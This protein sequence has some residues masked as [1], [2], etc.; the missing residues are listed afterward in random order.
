MEI[1]GSVKHAELLFRV[2]GELSQKA[3]GA[4]TPAVTIN[5]L[6]IE[7]PKPIHEWPA[8]Y[9]APQSVSHVDPGSRAGAGGWLPTFRPPD[10]HKSSQV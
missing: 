6:G 7:G 1:R 5:I 10:A 8:G 9:R 4:Q 2:T 3:G